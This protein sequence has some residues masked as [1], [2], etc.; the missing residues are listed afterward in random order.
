MVKIKPLLTSLLIFSCPAFGWEEGKTENFPLECAGL[1]KNGAEKLYV[2]VTAESGS[3]GMPYLIGTKSESEIWSIPFPAYEVDLAKFYFSCN[4]PIIT[5]SSAYPGPGKYNHEIFSFKN[6]LIYK[7]L[8]FEKGENS[9]TIYR[10]LAKGSEDHFLLSAKSGQNIEVS[11]NKENPTAIFSVFEP[12]SNIP[13]EETDYKY[14]KTE[15]SSVLKKSGEYAIA[16]KG[17]SGKSY[18]LTVKIN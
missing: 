13:I 10:M 3:D 17:V 6:G 2:R 12:K 14:N 4:A 8:K 1:E 15:W 5:L 11:I 16:V 18:Q 9:T 7:H